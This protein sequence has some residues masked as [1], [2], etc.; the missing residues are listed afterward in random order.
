MKFVLSVVFMAVILFALV[1][2]D[3]SEVENDAMDVAGRARE[4]CAPPYYYSCKK[5]NCCNQKYICRCDILYMNCKC[6][7]R[8]WYK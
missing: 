6:E 8:I 1:S 7:P 4:R 5:L 2:A 3:A